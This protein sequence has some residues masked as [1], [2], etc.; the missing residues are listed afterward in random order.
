MPL[1]RLARSPRIGGVHAVGQYLGELAATRQRDSP[2]RAIRQA[3]CPA[4]AAT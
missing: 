3:L 4:R 1:Q 2:P